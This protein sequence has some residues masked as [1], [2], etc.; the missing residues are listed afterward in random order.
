MTLVQAI[1]SRYGATQ[2]EAEAILRHAPIAAALRLLRY[3]F[4]PIGYDYAKLT[5]AERALV[6]PAEFAQLLPLLA[7]AEGGE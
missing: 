4:A 5:D 3:S 6:S 1:M 7:V 2:A